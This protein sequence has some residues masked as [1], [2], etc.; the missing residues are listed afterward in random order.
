MWGQYAARVFPLDV[1]T[2]TECMAVNIKRTG[3]QLVSMIHLLRNVLALP[4]LLFVALLTI[5]ALA[6]VPDMDRRRSIARMSAW[7]LLR[8][9]GVRLRVANTAALPA[10]ACVL[11]ANHTSYLDGLILTAAL[12]PQFAFVIKKEMSR[13]PVAGFVLRRI[14]SEFVDRFNRHRGAMDTRRVLRRASQGQSLVFFPEGTFS[15]EPGL[16]HFHSGAFATAVRANCPVVTAAIIGARAVLPP[17]QTLVSPGRVQVEILGV[18]E[19]RADENQ[20]AV[21]L[22]DEAREQIQRRL[23]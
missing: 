13:V 8:I 1:I 2:L 21:R 4:L 9:C 16:L 7:T 10:Q 17:G 15:K 23:G 11:V 12:P 6:V 3:S 5:L 22:R 18:L 14:G 19:P 20:V